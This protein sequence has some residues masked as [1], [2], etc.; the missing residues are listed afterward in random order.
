LPRTDLPL[1]VA[2]SDGTALPVRR[3]AD[4]Y[5]AGLPRRTEE[6]VVDVRLGPASAPL[7]ERT[8]VLPPSDNRELARTG[9]DRQTLLRL[10]GD[11]DRLDPPAGQ[12]LAAPELELARPRP[13]WLPFLL[14]AAIL[15]PFDAWARRRT[16]SVSR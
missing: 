15:L 14:I 7:L 9:P 4:R 3:R 2:L 16:R 8:L 1:E 13:L 11:P 12:A 6:T 5:E 10:V